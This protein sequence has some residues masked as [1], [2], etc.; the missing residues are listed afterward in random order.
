MGQNLHPIKQSRGQQH[1]KELH[2]RVSSLNDCNRA[3]E[4]NASDVPGK[5]HFNMLKEN[6]RSCCEFLMFLTVVGLRHSFILL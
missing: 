4:L 6:S 1:G 2:T 3:L 5:T